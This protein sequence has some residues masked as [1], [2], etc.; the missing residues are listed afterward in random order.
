LPSPL[1]TPRARVRLFDGRLQDLNVERWMADADEV[2][3]RILDRTR[4]PVLDVGC[5]PGRH[6]EALTLRGT[7]VLGLDLSADFVAMA[8]RNQ[9]PVLLQS[10]FD[11][12]PGGSRWRC[13]LILDGSIGIGGDPG[14]LLRRVRHLLTAGGRVLVET[15][16]PDE[17][18]E[19]LSLYIE[20]ETGDGNVFEWATLSAF[21]AAPVAA[22]SGFDLTD[23]WEDAGRWFVQLEKRRWWSA[24]HEAVRRP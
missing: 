12:V 4:G 20:S 9:R 11:P 7:E 22:R 10:V 23:L 16:T 19:T 13:A 8:Q 3:H 15:G 24:P 5:G 6:V 17:P 18:T 2:D 1:V 14:M 21:D